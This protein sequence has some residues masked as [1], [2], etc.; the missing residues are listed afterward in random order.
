MKLINRSSL[1]LLILLFALS[2]QAAD[3]DPQLP[4]TTPESGFNAPKGTAEPQDA[5]KVQD[6][7][8]ATS[9]MMSE[10]RATMDLSRGEISELM[11]TAAE[12]NDFVVKQTIQTAIA[13]IKKQTELDILG[14][15]AQYALSTGNEELARQIT[16]AI[17]AI[18]SPP[19]PVAPAEPRPAPG[20]QN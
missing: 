12:T 6:D 13:D 17:A 3:P 16:E 7:L 8:S 18:T 20:N 9:P 19:A 11:V 4:K 1:V 15:Q 5:A 14:I 10:I 2:A